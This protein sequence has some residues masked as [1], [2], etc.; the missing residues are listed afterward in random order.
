MLCANWLTTARSCVMKRQARPRRAWIR[1][2]RLRTCACTVTSRADVISSHSK[3]SG[4]AAKARAR[5]MRCCCPPESWRGWRGRYSGPRSIS[6]RRASAVFARFA[7]AL[8]KVK[9]QGPRNNLLDAM[10]G[11]QRRQRILKHHLHTPAR[12]FAACLGKPFQLGAIAQ[13]DLAAMPT[14]GARDQ[15]GERRF[16]RSRLAHNTKRLARVQ[17]QRDVS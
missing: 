1:C 5:A 12:R 4:S 9:A 8:S 11:I 2:K 16:A 3:T 17:L 6:P 13:R 7:G 10:R 15:A 14:D